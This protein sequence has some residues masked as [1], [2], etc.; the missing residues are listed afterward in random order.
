ME[1]ENQS[2][3]VRSLSGN[4]TMPGFTAPKIN[5]LK[6]NE[7]DNFNKIFKVLLPKIIYVFI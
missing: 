3:D 4:I 5:W 2:F 1:F 7:H 6:K